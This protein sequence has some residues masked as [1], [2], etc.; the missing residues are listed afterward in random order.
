M[1]AI[2]LLVNKYNK[3]VAKLQKKRHYE[4]FILANDK[5]TVQKKKK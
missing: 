5:K 4:L 1:C 3:S 2:L